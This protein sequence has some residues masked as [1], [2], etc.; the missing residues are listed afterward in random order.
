MIPRQATTASFSTTRL[1]HPMMQAALPKPLAVMG[2]LGPTA[3]TPK[4]SRQ[5]PGCPAAAG[6]T[7]ANTP[8]P[9]T[10]RR[11][12]WAD[13]RV[14]TPGLGPLR[15]EEQAGTEERWM[16]IVPACSMITTRRQAGPG[17]LPRRPGQTPG[18]AGQ[19]QRQIHRSPAAT[20][21][22]G[23]ASLAIYAIDSSLSV[24]GCVITRGQAG[25]GGRGGN[26]GQGQCGGLGG[27]GGAA[28]GAAAGGRG[29][30][31]ADQEG[32]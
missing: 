15:T 3:S 28:D 21:R 25:D 11:V 2:R 9:A 30:A 12:D 16:R 5:L 14:P 32:A 1:P 18:T 10:I 23:G 19:A 7:P 22:G 8:L 6:A 29:R 4:R 27:P 20:G 17:R 24:N 13:R 26:G 31:F